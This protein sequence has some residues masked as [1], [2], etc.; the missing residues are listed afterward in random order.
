MRQLDRRFSTPPLSAPVLPLH[1]PSTPAKQVVTPR[2]LLQLDYMAA[3]LKADIMFSI[4]E[5]S[6]KVRIQKIKK[7]V[8]ISWAEKTLLERQVEDLTAANKL[9]KRRNKH[10]QAVITKGRLMTMED[11]KRIRAEEAAREAEKVEKAERSRARLTQS[12]SKQTD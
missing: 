5:T 8:A 10:N 2:S 12:S 11:V 3:R 9:K 1:P 4:L 6:L 7:T